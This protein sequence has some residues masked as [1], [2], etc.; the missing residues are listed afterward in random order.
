MSRVPFAYALVDK[1]HKPFADGDRDVLLSLAQVFVSWGFILMLMLG[2]LGLFFFLRV[3][4]SG[5]AQDY[6]VRNDWVITEATIIRILPM[7]IGGHHNWH[8]Y[9]TFETEDGEQVLGKTVAGRGNAF[10]EGQRI[11]VRYLRT[12]PGENVY[13]DEKMP[14]SVLYWVFVGMGTLFVY[15]AANGVRRSVS[16]YRTMRA[17]SHS[18]QAVAGEIISVHRPAWHADE[19]NVKVEYIFTSPTGTRRVGRDSVPEIHVAGAPKPGTVVAV[20]CVG[21]AVALLL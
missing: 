15:T 16:L 10:R 14:K 9:Y 3:G 2:G 13:A 5:L 8:F 7:Y 4:V 21:D 20:W 6:A 17:I 1:R 12:D 11:P 18:G 19:R